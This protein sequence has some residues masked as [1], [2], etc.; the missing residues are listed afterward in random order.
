MNELAISVRSDVDAWDA[1][2]VLLGRRR[3]RL[4]FE[5]GGVPRI[6]GGTAP[7]DQ[8]PAEK[9]QRQHIGDGEDK[10]PD[11]R[12]HVPRLEK[13]GVVMVGARQAGPAPDE[14]RE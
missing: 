6:G 13:G 9:N 14:I 11:R 12:Q 8:R 10:S 4:P 1:V 5:P 3:T 7:I 2:E